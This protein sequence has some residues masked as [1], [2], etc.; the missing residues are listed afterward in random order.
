M[1]IAMDYICEWRNRKE[2]R[3]EKFVLWCVCM[4]GEVWQGNLCKG[5]GKG[6]RGFWVEV[7]WLMSV[8]AWV[9]RFHLSQNPTQ[10]NLN[11]SLLFCSVVFVVFHNCQS[12]TPSSKV[13]F[14]VSL[15]TKSALISFLC[16]S[17]GY[18][19]KIL[20]FL[21]SIHQFQLFCI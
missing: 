12:S 15:V 14:F 8:V 5:K 20:M 2:K 17:I 16:F 7:S 18:S 13:R 6:K 10:P 11:H 19:S 3:E 1:Q 21:S 4:V 9:G